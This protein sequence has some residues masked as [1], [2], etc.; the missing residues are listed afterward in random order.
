[1]KIP[2]MKIPLDMALMLADGGMAGDY[3]VI[4]YKG[5]EI[6]FADDEYKPEL[7]PGPFFVMDQELDAQEFATLDGARQFIDSGEARD[8]SADELACLRK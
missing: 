8:L 6:L 3:P 7:R 2:E 5:S 1:M 4:L